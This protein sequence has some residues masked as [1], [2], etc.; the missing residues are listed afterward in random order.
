ML[1]CHKFVISYTNVRAFQVKQNI[2]AEL[3]VEAT[4]EDVC[5]DQVASKTALT[6]VRKHKNMEDHDGPVFPQTR[7]VAVFH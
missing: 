7:V 1:P 3:T 4:N 5:A 6:Y 2:L